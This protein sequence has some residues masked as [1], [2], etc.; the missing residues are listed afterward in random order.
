M[1]PIRRSLKSMGFPLFSSSAKI[2]PAS[3]TEEEERLRRVSLCWS[4]SSDSRLCCRNE[5][6]IAP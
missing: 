6:R 1:V 3:L 4:F 2:L 5:E